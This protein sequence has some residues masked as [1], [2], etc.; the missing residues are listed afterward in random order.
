[1][2][3]LTKNFSLWEFQCPQSGVSVPSPELVA[4]LQVL[5]D[6]VG[7]RVVIH[8]GTR[9]RRYNELIGGA[10]D[11]AHLVHPIDKDEPMYY[12][13]AA[14]IEVLGVPHQITGTLCQLIFEGIGL[15]EGHVHVDIRPW[16]ART[17]KR[18]VVIMAERFFWIQD[19]LDA[20]VL[21]NLSIERRVRD[22]EWYPEEYGKLWASTRGG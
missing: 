2:G 17:D 9:S 8:S 19:S 1:M 5:R 7:R 12:S 6:F 16:V 3:D 15:Y 22:V 21:T 13:Y 10:K 11:S 14:D 18:E 4:R 20:N